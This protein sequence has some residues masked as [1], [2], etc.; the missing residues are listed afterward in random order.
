[1]TYGSFCVNFKFIYIQ[2]IQ[3]SYKYLF[4]LRDLENSVT[5]HRRIQGCLLMF[6]SSFMCSLGKL[7]G[8]KLSFWK[9]LHMVS[10]YTIDD[11]YWSFGGKVSNKVFPVFEWQYIY[12]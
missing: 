11:T 1:M 9:K 2:L 6:S 4:I 7:T 8:N 12:I 3:N 10:N 5:Y